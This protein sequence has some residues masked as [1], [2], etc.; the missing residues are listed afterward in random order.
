MTYFTKDRG[1]QPL[2]VGKID[3]AQDLRV[4]IMAVRI[5]P[6]A[7]QVCVIAKG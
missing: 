1:E 4:I 3:E 7:S 5:D 2:L 6:F